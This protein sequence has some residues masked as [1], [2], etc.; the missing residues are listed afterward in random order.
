[1]AE[2]IRQTTEAEFLAHVLPGEE[3]SDKPAV[4]VEPE[5]PRR[6]QVDVSA[7]DGDQTVNCV[8]LVNAVIKEAKERHSDDPALKALF[9]IYD[10][11]DEL[12]EKFNSR[13]GWGY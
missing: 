8:A 13:I 2:K 12:S 4:A 7:P 1:M 10:E 11:I 9:G 5:N 3:L 6:S